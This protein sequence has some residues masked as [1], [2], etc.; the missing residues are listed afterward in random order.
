[1]YISSSTYRQHSMK[2]SASHKLSPKFYGPFRVIDRVDLVAYK[3]ELPPSAAIH[4]VF[5]V[6]QLKR[7]SNP[8][9]VP[10]TLPQ[11]L[12][13]LGKSKEPEAILDRKM[14][15]RHNQAVTKVRVQWK[16]QPKDQATWEF[17]QDFIATYPT[18]HP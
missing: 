16:G 9:A 15:K 11:Y 8:P 17:Y 13:D 6:S 5:H 18:F 2:T 1:M 4:N 3:L 12:L 10:T 7:C 14:V